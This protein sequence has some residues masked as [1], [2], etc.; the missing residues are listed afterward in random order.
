M[1]TSSTHSRGNSTHGGGGDRRRIGD[2]PRRIRP[3]VGDHDDVLGPH[4]AEQVLEHLHAR[5]PTRP[6]PSGSTPPTM[7]S[8]SRIS[9][10]APPSG[11]TSVPNQP[12]PSQFMTC[13]N[14]SMKG[15]IHA[16]S[17]SF[18][19]VSIANG[20]SPRR[21]IHA[22]SRHESGDQQ[23]RRRT[24]SAARRGTLDVRRAARAPSPHCVVRAWSIR[25][26]LARAAGMMAPCPGSSTSS[27]PSSRPL[28]RTRL[29]RRLG[30]I[31]LPPIEARP[32]ASSPAVACS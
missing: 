12:P 13:E 9:A 14:P 26:M 23:R 30:P 24:N 10:I 8:C 6:R 29:F 7:A 15:E 20:S 1:P 21:K 19:H 25:A 2:V 18:H 16:A 22:P 32:V 28:T 4:P 31:V 5:R 11:T 27:A 17:T 3:V